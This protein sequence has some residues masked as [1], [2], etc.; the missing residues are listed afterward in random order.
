MAFDL[1]SNT[2]HRT[3][4]SCLGLSRSRGGTLEVVDVLKVLQHLASF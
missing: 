3:E 4:I 2:A 1:E